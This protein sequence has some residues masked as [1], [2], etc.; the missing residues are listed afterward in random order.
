MGLAELVQSNHQ[1]WLI[2]KYRYQPQLN[3]YPSL[4]HTWREIEEE[5]HFECEPLIKFLETRPYYY[6]FIQ[7]GRKYNCVHAYFTPGMDR[8][9]PSDKAKHRAMFGLRTKKNT[10]LEWWNDSKYYLR[11]ETVIAGHYHLVKRIPNDN[12]PCVVLLDS[13]C[14]TE[15]GQL[16]VYDVAKNDILKF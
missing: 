12:N 16:P 4:L 10:R 3:K 7:N 13:N 11:E 9:N 14:G 15:G 1:Y 2:Q 5:G 8:Y 6:S